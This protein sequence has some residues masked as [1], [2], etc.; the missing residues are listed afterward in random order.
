MDKKVLTIGETLIRLN[1]DGYYSGVNTL[2]YFIGGDALNVASLL[3]YNGNDVSYLTF[4]DKNHVFYKRILEH[5][6]MHNINTS[7]VFEGEGRLGTYYYIGKTTTK[8]QRVDYD[9]TFSSFSQSK[10]SMQLIYGIVKDKFSWIHMSATTLS[11]NKKMWKHLHELYRDASNKKIMTSLDLT[12]EP[13]AWASYGLYLE[14]VE[15]M[16]ENTRFLIGWFDKDEMKEVKPSFTLDD[17]KK[18]MNVFLA[19]YLNVK[20]IVTPLKIVNKGK[21]YLKT[22]YYTNNCFYETEAVEFKEAFANGSIDAFIAFLIHRQLKDKNLKT[23]VEYATKAYILNNWYHGD[24]PE[25]TEEEL[26]DFN[27]KILPNEDQ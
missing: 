21:T 25:I 6:N 11:L 12:Y 14:A 4:L 22:Y 2:R 17:Y 23:A 5:F 27:I 8:S 1:V 16:L 9:R 13:E 24:S 7:Y 20:I 10:L 18:K 15:P 19:K 26:E 3:G